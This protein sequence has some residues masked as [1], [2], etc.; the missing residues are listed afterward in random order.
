MWSQLGSDFSVIPGEPPECE[1]YSTVLKQRGWPS[2]RAQAP[3]CQSLRNCSAAGTGQRVSG[4]CL[5]KDNSLEKEQLR[6]VSSQHSQQL[7]DGHTSW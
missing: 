6:A 2:D 4:S 5:A 7:G 3:E 1:S